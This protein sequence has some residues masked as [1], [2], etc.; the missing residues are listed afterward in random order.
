MGLWGR[1]LTHRGGHCLRLCVSY[2][3]REHAN[4]HKDLQL[5]LDRCGRTP[6]DTAYIVREKPV[7]RYHQ[8]GVYLYTGGW[9]QPS[10]KN[11]VVICESSS[12]AGRA[13]DSN[14]IAGCRGRVGSRP[15]RIDRAGIGRRNRARPDGFGLGGARIGAEGRGRVRMG[16]AG[17]LAARNCSKP[18]RAAPCAGDTR[19]DQTPLDNT[20]PRQTSPNQT[21]PR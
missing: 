15:A 10:L 18:Y 14:V 8:G 5:P 16:E 9:G 6:P 4:L 17:C 13:R 3:E 2:A 7:P 20:G 11:D 1:L 21:G 12:G 19:R